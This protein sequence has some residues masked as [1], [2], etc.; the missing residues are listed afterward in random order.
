MSSGL[1]DEE[2]VKKQ[3]QQKPSIPKSGCDEL[4]RL[5]K[6]MFKKT[7]KRVQVDKLMKDTAFE[8]KEVFIVIFKSERDTL[9]CF[10]SS[11][12]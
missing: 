4:N 11:T 5:M 8:V 1:F 3:I 6:S 7:C 12:D 10:F 9:K 2:E